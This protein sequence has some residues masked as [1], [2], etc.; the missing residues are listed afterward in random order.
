MI[1]PYPRYARAAR[2]CAMAAPS[3]S[4]TT[5]C[6]TCRCG[7]SWRGWIPICWRAIARLA[8]LVEKGRGF[9]EDDKAALRAVELELLRARGPGLPRG[10]R[11]RAGRACRRRRSITRSCRCCATRTRTSAR[12]PARRCR[13]SGSRVPRTRGCRSSARSRFTRRRSAAGRRACGRRKD[14][15]RTRRSALIAAAGLTWIATDEDILAR[16]LDSAD[17]RRTCCTARIAS[18]TARPGARLFRDHALSDRIGFHYQSWDAGAAAADFVEQVRDAGRRFARRGGGEVATVPVILD[19]ENAWEHYDGGGRPFLRALYQALL[20]APR[21]RD[22][23]DVAR[24][25]RARR[26]RCRRSFPAR[27]STATSTS[28]SAI[29]T[30]TGPGISCRTRARRS[31]RARPTWP[32]RG[33]RPGARGTADRRRQRLVLV[34][35]RRPFVG[36]RPR[37]RRPV[38]AP[39]AQR[40]HGARRAGP[41]GAVRDQHQHRRRSRIGSSRRA[42]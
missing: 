13:A 22:R 16:S 28:G 27:G 8:A 24:R 30:T 31:T 38:P 29:A 7:T 32:R 15:C 2:A 5:T 40:L 37:L 18:A 23:H 42:C 36:P 34:V 14:R 26:S 9:N 10:R 33:A 1:G 21:H 41:R 20:E 19:G 4:P 25:P 3:R 17:A 39:S 6:A 11:A 12:I 35:R